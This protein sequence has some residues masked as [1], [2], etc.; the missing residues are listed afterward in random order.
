MSDAK[1]YDPPYLYPDYVTTRLR[2]PLQPLVTLPAGF[3]DFPAP[4]LPYPS[5]ANALDLTRQHAGEPMG[6]RIIVTGRVLDSDGHPVADTMVE[7]WQAN[8]AGRYLDQEDQ[9]PAPSASNFHAAAGCLTDPPGRSPFSAV[10][11]SDYP[12]R[13]PSRT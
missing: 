5:A 13:T 12:G 1:Q 8:A 10:A 3:L 11:H 4:R 2:A 7:I 6:E 9:H